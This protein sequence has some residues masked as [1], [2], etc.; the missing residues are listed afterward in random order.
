MTLIGTKEITSLLAVFVRRALA[1][2]AN[3]EL[4]WPADYVLVVDARDDSDPEDVID[5]V[6]EL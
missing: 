1:I 6:N 5:D 2:F 4:A 3:M